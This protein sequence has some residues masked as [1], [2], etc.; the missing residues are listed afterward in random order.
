MQQDLDELYSLAKEKIQSYENLN[1]NTVDII[2]SLID[3]NATGL[4][5][6]YPESCPL[7]SNINGIYTVN[8]SGHSPFAVYCDT[9]MAGP[10]WTVIQRRTN[11]DLNFYRNWTQYMVGFG[12]LSNEFFIGLDKLHAITASRVHELYIQLE[13]FSGDKRFARYDEFLISGASNQYKLAKLGAYSGDAGDSL[14]NHLE[15]KFSTF[16]RDNDGMNNICSEK[17]IGAWWYGGS[18]CAYRLLK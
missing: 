3:S 17:L 11:G 7:F 5:H 1:K 14:K 9:K 2:R 8:V 13:D 16:D 12:N 18:D 15:Q 10:G 4:L 6:N